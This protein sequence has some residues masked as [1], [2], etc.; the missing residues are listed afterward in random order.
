[1]TF[2]FV[3]KYAVLPQARL[4]GSSESGMHRRPLADF[5]FFSLPFS[6]FHTLEIP[7]MLKLA[8]TSCLIFMTYTVR[9]RYSQWY[10]ISFISSFYVIGKGSNISDKDRI[11]KVAGL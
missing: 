8:S 9:T 3:R 11:V 1:M 2:N 4:N 6:L 10:L 5:D 7:S